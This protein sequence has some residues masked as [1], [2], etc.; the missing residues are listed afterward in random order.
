M[1]ILGWYFTMADFAKRFGA[2]R[3]LD[4]FGERILG[5]YYEKCK[6]I[7]GTPRPLLSSS[8]AG[9][10]C[11]VYIASTSVPGSLEPSR[12]NGMI[13]GLKDALGENTEPQWIRLP[14]S[15]L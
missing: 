8:F 10:C 5:P 14:V 4:A 7:T 6:V 11:I 2:G 15:P 3:P 12:L 13:E 9:K 1:Y